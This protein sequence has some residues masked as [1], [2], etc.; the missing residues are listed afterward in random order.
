MDLAWLTPQPQLRTAD[1]AKY[2]E[3][4]AGGMFAYLA[5]SAVL[6][7]SFILSRLILSRD[8]KHPRA[9]QNGWKRMTLEVYKTP[10][11][12]VAPSE[13]QTQPGLVFGLV[14]FEQRQHVSGSRKM[15]EQRF[16][17]SAPGKPWSGNINYHSAEDL[18]GNH[19]VQ[20][21]RPLTRPSPVGRGGSIAPHPVSS[22]GETSRCHAR[23]PLSPGERAR[24]RANQRNLNSQPEPGS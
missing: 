21:L 13:I 8:N 23:N 3:K 14:W 20:T 2:A 4:L 17:R 5:Y 11:G 10:A 6:Q 1:H 9:G 18:S 22:P 24:V 19:A 16:R 7:A 15:R 12:S